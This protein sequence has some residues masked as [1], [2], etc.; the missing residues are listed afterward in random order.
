M[1]SSTGL[2]DVV[3]EGACWAAESVVECDRGGEGEEA[4]ADPGG[5][6]VQGAG[7]VAFEGEQVFTGLE[8]RFDPLPDR[9]DVRPLAGLVFA[10]W[11]DDRGVEFGGGV[12][13]LA[14]GVAEIADHEQMAVALAALEQGQADVAFGHFW[15]GQHQR[16]WRPVEREQAV[17]AEAPEKAAVACAPAV[18]GGV[19]ELAAPGRLEAAGAFDRGRIDQDEIVVE[20]GAVTRET[21]MNASIV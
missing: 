1:S 3:D 14:A 13:E 18:V 2:G 5:Q 16:A 11:P 17:Q 21:A 15:R 20:T 10:F 4:C 6:A 8:D 19:G 9:R 7:A 12:F